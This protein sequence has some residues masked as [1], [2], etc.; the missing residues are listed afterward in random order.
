MRGRAGRKGKDTFGEN[1]LC[2]YKKDLAPVKELLSAGMPTVKS[3]L[4]KENG[5]LKR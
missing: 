3:C 1:Y 2:C 4:G 5:G